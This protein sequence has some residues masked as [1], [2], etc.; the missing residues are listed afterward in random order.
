MKLLVISI[1]SRL[2]GHDAVAHETVAACH[3]AAADFERVDFL[4]AH[5]LTP[6]IAAGLSGFDAVLFVDADAGASRVII[7]RVSADPNAG[8]FSHSIPPSSVLAL[9][10]A[11]FGFHGQA[12]LCRVPASDFAFGAPAANSADDIKHAARRIASFMRKLAS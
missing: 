12:W 10:G 7:E 8:Q 6:E 9:A 5:Q 11:L 1:G 3:P 2:R 4:E